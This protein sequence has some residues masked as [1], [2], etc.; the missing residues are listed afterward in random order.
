MMRKNGLEIILGTIEGK[1]RSR[2]P[3]ATWVY[4]EKE[5][6]QLELLE[7]HRAVLDSTEWRRMLKEGHQMSAKT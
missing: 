7:L 2:H 4:G 3:R 1:K 6:A 5:M